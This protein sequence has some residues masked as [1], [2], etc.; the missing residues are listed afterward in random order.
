MS[1][2]NERACTKCGS[3]LH[4]ENDCPTPNQPEAV[5]EAELTNDDFTLRRQTCKCCGRPDGFNFY[6]PTGVWEAVVPEK[7]RGRVVCLLCFDRLAHQIN[8]DYTQHISG[9]MFVGDVG[10]LD[11]SISRRLWVNQPI[12]SSSPAG[13]GWRMLDVG[14]VI[15]EGDEFEDALSAAR[16][17]WLPAIATIGQKVPES[18]FFRRRVPAQPEAQWETGTPR[19]DYAFKGD[20]SVGTQPEISTWDEAYKLCQFLERDLSAAL[21]RC[22]EADKELAAFVAHH[23]A[24]D[25]II[26]DAEGQSPENGKALLC[27]MDRLKARVSELEQELA[28]VREGE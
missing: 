21:A 11:L 12:Q 26:R 28:R 19:S 22:A 7:L 4:H 23:E 2:H 3:L 1:D 27:N 5:D 9:V 13:D 6:V 15:Q 25:L 18:D 17:N 10:H 16:G 24:T 8:F 14:E 20:L